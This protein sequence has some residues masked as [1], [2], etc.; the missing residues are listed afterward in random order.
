MWDCRLEG[1]FFDRTDLTGTQLF[2][3]LLN[4]SSFRKTKLVGTRF[5]FAVASAGT[6]FNFLDMSEVKGVIF[7]STN[8]S[9]IRHKL[10][11][12]FS[13]NVTFGCDDT[14][15]STRLSDEY[16]SIMEMKESLEFDDLS[17]EDT[18]RY[19]EQINNSG[20]RYWSP[21][22]DNDLIT[23]QYLSEFMETFGLTGWPHRDE[24]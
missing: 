21:Y 12:N 13:S 9:G 6:M 5:D 7:R 24:E 2:R 8:L 20:F 1:T 16:R 4:F 17:P 3:S 15:L 10:A 18:Q 23:D 11:R 19:Q 22:G 14:T